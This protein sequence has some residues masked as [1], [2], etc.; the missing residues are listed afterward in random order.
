V[1]TGTRV[2]RLVVERGHGTDVYGGSR[3]GTS[4]VIGWG[5][6]GWS[7]LGFWKGCPLQH[8][9]YGIYTTDTEF[10][11]LYRWVST[12]GPSHPNRCHLP[13]LLP[14]PIWVNLMRDRLELHR[15]IRR[16]YYGQST[17]LERLL[18]TPGPFWARHYVFWHNRKPLTVIFEVFSP[19]LL[20]RE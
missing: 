18:G 14:Q 7:R 19:A 9:F 13:Y 20:D 6:A 17:A 15:D 1:W 5:E 12:K 11:R 8:H 16:V 3:S 2:R 10:V 4:Q